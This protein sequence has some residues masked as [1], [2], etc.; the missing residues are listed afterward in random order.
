M[1][2]KGGKFQPEALLFFYVFIFN[3]HNFTYQTNTF[4][5]VSDNLLKFICVKQRIVRVSIQLN[6]NL[7]L[8]T[9]C[10]SIVVLNVH[11]HINEL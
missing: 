4:Y 3:I 6:I 9:A 2:E 8:L 10:N 7:T 11:I 1:R 5:S